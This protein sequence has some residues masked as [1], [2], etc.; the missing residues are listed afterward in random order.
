MP[1]LSKM[2]IEKGLVGLLEPGFLKESILITPKLEAEVT[3]VSA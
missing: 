2:V 1:E 3:V